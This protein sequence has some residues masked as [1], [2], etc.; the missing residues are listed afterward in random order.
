MARQLQAQV[1]RMAE[2]V[3][4]AIVSE[5]PLYAD[6]FRGGLGVNIEGAIRAALEGFLALAESSEATRRHPDRERVHDAAYALGQGEA[7]AGRPIDALTAAYGV[8]AR[9]AWR[10][11]G[12]AA[13]DA[14]LS[15]TEVA[16]LAE[17]VF[18]F[19]N[20]ISVRSIN[21]HADALASRGQIRQRRRE[22]LCLKLI[23]GAAEEELRAAAELAEWPPPRRLCALLLDQ[24]DAD[25]LITEL[26]PET[27]RPG[28]DLPGVETGRTVLLV[29]ASRE[30]DR[31][32]LSGALIGALHGRRAVVGPATAWSA[33]RASHLRVLAC[34]RLEVADSPGPVD[35]E[36]H[37]LE[38]VLGADPAALA[39]LRRRVLAPLETVSATAAE[40]L[41]AT[42]RAWL[43]HQGRRDDVARALFVHPQ[44]VRY[45]MGQLR[46]LFGEA[47]SDPRQVLE[48]TVALA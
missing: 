2:R 1:P 44:T 28:E 35:S 14:G 48:L 33:V 36:A 29:P 25:A 23:E 5:V 37:L 9:A 45:R 8:G 31:G 38:L 30:A 47:L 41:I 3:L 20:D 39:D 16:R 40:K 17:L 46:D 24:E 12:G 6:P 32:A 19:I 11:L 10:D 7:R 34:A 22:R 15:S 27:L 21:G 18:S 13:I 42:L 4:A 26:D 43:L